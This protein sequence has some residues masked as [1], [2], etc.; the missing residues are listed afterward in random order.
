MNDL[1]LLN[2]DGDQLLGCD[3]VS[4]QGRQPV[5]LQAVT[6]S[7]AVIELATDPAVRHIAWL[8]QRWAASARPVHEWPALLRQPLELLHYGAGQQTAR[9]GQA[10]GFVYFDT[11]YLLPAPTGNRVPTWLV[12]PAAGICRGDLFSTHLFDPN[13]PTWTV[14]LWAFAYRLMAG[15]AFPYSTPDLFTAPDQ[16]VAT[17]PKLVFTTWE[18]A[19]FVRRVYGAKWLPFWLAGEWW[20]RQRLPLATALRAW[21]T[22]RPPA[23]D[24]QP[25]Q[26]LH[27]EVTESLTDAQE[28]GDQEVD[29]ILPTL[30]RPEHLQ[31]VLEDLARQTIP[32]CTV[33]VVDQRLPADADVAT[34]MPTLFRVEGKN[35]PFRL[36]HTVVNWVGACRARNLA[37]AKASSRWVLFLDDDVR[38]DP[39][40]LANMLTAARRYQVGAVN[41]T[42]VNPPFKKPTPAVP[43][44]H[45][46]AR[47]GTCAGL[48]ERTFATA[49]GGFDER[50]EG[51]FGEDTEYGI[52]LRLTGANIICLPNEIVRHLKAPRGGFRFDYPH[53][54]RGGAVKPNPSP[55]VMLPRLIHDSPDMLAG[56]RLHYTLGALAHTS[57][58]RW[59]QKLREVDQGWAASLHWAAYLRDHSPA[60]TRCETVKIKNWKRRKTG[61]NKHLRQ[62]CE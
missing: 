17:A 50:L 53:P 23:M 55:T 33:Y 37:L 15:G 31:N 47:F 40:F 35:W 36:D 34:K 13:A 46:W 25:L 4:P 3:R 39:V 10:L 38:L 6:P 56:Y 14:A 43:W 2:L 57:C 19:W 44:P 26:A 45:A 7:A 58:W 28:D 12:S 9:A 62:E 1:I 27:A 29:V 59:P 24:T 48:V 49:I 8:D 60:P 20:R 52:R 41:A 54:W 22:S 30:C 61:S 32:P 11:P 5:R 42:V 51:G 16:A 18:A 21:F